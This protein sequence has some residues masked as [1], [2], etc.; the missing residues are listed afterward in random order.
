MPS[1]KR[2]LRHWG[3][4]QGSARKAF[5][6]EAQHR[7][8]VAVHAGEQHHRGELRVAIETSMPVGHAWAGVTPRERARM[9]FGAL[10]VWNTEDHSGVLLYINL[11]D[12]AVELLADRGID[13]RVSQTAWRQICDDLA[14]G[15]ARDLSVGPV[16]DAIARIHALLIEHYPANGGHNPNELDD[17][18][19]VL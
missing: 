17:R 3:T 12:H 19:F 13:A 1:L 9:L 6:P 10:E 7:L 4:G 8:Q 5:P 15:L 14:R 18:P 2:A 11:A 16:L